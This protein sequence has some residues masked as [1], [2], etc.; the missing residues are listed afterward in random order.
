MKTD[1]HDSI[2]T[3]DTLVMVNELQRSVE[4]PPSPLEKDPPMRFTLHSCG[5]AVFFAVCSFTASQA[6]TIAYSISTGAF[7]DNLGGGSINVYFSV[8]DFDSSLGT[9]TSIGATL[10]GSYTDIPY[11]QNNTTYPDIARFELDGK[12]G[13]FFSDNGTNTTAAAGATYTFS[14]TG[15]DGVSQDLAAYSHAGGGMNT[16]L[17]EVSTGGEV[18]SPGFTGTLTYTYTPATVTSP[19]T[20]TPEPASLMLLGTGVL[21]AAG[22]LRRRW[23]TL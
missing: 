23:S 19:T 15:T 18:T 9:L 17:L 21:G 2:T 5:A 3:D 8:P 10:G 4:D 13:T 16:L 12:M 1:V 6:A 14:G 7:T 20:V 22:A 11:T